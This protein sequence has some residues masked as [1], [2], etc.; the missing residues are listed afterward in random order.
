MNAKLKSLVGSNIKLITKRETCGYSRK[1]LATQIA[2]YLYTDTAAAI[3]VQEI[4]R[5][6]RNEHQPNIEYKKALCAILN[7]TPEELGFSSRSKIMTSVPAYLPIEKNYTGRNNLRTIFQEKLAANKKKTILAVHGVGG[8]GKSAFIA[9]IIQ[10]TAAIQTTFSDGVLWITCENFTGARGYN[11]FLRH[12]ADKIKAA[13][14]LSA[15]IQ[16]IKHTLLVYFSKLNHCLIILDDIN[17]DL[18]KNLKEIFELLCAEKNTTLILISRQKI[19]SADRC[20]FDVPMPSLTNAEANTLMARLLQEKTN[21]RPDL[22]EWNIIPNICQTV[23]NHPLTIHLLSA[24]YSENNILI[25]NDYQNLQQ[26]FSQTKVMDTGLK[27]CFERYHRLLSEFK[28]FLLAALTLLDGK[29]IAKAIIISMGQALAEAKHHTID[30]SQEI[31]ELIQSSIVTE[32]GDDDVTIHD[33]YRE[34][35][36]NNFQTKFSQKDQTLIY[37]L[38]ANVF[39]DYAIQ[40]REHVFDFHENMIGKQ[41]T[42]IH[43]ALQWANEQQNYALIG[44]ICLGMSGYWRTNVLSEENITWQKYIQWG[45]E[46]YNKLLQPLRAETSEYRFVMMEKVSIQNLHAWFYFNRRELDS[47]KAIYTETIQTFQTLQNIRGICSTNIALCE[48]AMSNGDWSAAALY[49]AT[50]IQLLD[51]ELKKPENTERLKLLRNRG[52]AETMEAKIAWFHEEYETAIQKLQNAEQF[53]KDSQNDWGLVTCW[54][55]LGH[56]YLDLHH[57]VKMAFQYVA[58]MQQTDLRNDDDVAIDWVLSAKILV[59]NNQLR[60]AEQIL[61]RYISEHNNIVF[62]EYLAIANYILGV[63]YYKQHKQQKACAHFQEAIQL[64]SAHFGPITKNAQRYIAEISG[65]ESMIHSK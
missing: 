61:L 49:A 50:A 36:L 25:Q 57:D 23:V 2:R 64:R 11:R 12:L 16:Q 65:E 5:W 3:D 21:E 55:L 1:K 17:P 40:Y 39:A 53:F 18:E 46:A 19:N 20:I 6:E 15:T 22:P 34:Y 8:I 9:T 35:I 60:N 29:Y 42:N 54:S 7:A 59:E 10:T 37:S 26:L 24:Y 52:E 63:I 43:N 48:T 31:A 56:I 27:Q 14:P 38:L 32:A 58:K 28:Q 33:I 13:D 4:G 45:I 41:E 30:M 47:A 51:A 44:K 62:Y